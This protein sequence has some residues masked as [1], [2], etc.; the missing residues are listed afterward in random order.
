MNNQIKGKRSVKS[1]AA[2]ALRKSD[3]S[4]FMGGVLGCFAF[5]GGIYAALYI[6]AQI[7]AWYW[8]F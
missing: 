5:I 1:L 7:G 2:Q 3:F 6:A 4:R 8:G